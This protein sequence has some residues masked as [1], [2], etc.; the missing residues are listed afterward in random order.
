MAHG[1]LNYGRN[2]WNSLP[3]F[4]ILHLK[5]GV[6]QSV[7]GIMLPSIQASISRTNRAWCGL[8]PPY[9]AE[10]R[11][12]KGKMHENATYYKVI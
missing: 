8:I 7:E 6:L 2:I 5:M 12:M 4:H 10:D 3:G 9:T 1:K 11:G